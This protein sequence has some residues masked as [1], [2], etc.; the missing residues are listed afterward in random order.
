[1]RRFVP[2]LLTATLVPGVLGDPDVTRLKLRAQVAVNTSRVTLGDVLSFANGGAELAEKLGDEPALVQPVA[3]A[4]NFVTHE[5]ILRRLEELGVNL[6]RV[7]VSG[8]SVCEV[9]FQKSAPPPPP[10][11][12]KP[13]D[14]P[15][16]ET[17]AKPAGARALADVL[18]DH[19]SAEIRALGGTAELQF[20][21]AGQEFL[22]LTTPPWEF[23]VTSSGTD[24]LGLREFRV[25]IRREGQVQRTAEV[26]AH[27]RIVRQ[28]VV[29]R[30]P[31]SIG[32]S[33]RTDDVGLETRVF[34]DT[35][36]LGLAEIER[37]IGQQV[38]RFVP[39]GELVQPDA[40]K[41]VDLVQRSRPVTVLGAG[42]PVQVRLSGVALDSGTYGDSVRVRLGESPRG[43][44]L[45]RG[46]VTA[47][48]TVR[49]V[50]GT[51]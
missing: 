11:A 18:R 17:G 15:L 23:I 47:V 45:L 41:A 4:K 24:K 32:N 10:T 31:L 2:L 48:G 14:G 1:M 46:V 51:P 29:A 3:V 22:Q 9:T 21:R 44:Q 34:D 26:S 28:V 39:A 49:I 27:A 12:G 6:A 43:Q 25:V 30:R 20:E 35:G 8:A 16:R 37:V 33:V 36:K 42:G 5:Q 40:L 7:L 38:K 13:T 50:E 19:V